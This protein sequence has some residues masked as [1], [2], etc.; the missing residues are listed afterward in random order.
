MGEMKRVLK[1]SGTLLVTVSFGRYA[2]D[3][4]GSQQR[5]NN[6]MIDECVRLVVP[7]EI[8]QTFYKQSSRGWDLSDADARSD[9]DYNLG[10]FEDMKSSEDHPVRAGAAHV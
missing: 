7:S 4:R 8:G 9:A 1:P 2:L 5:L 10:I 3:L 6:Q